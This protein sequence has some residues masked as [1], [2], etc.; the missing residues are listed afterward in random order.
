M[1]LVFY[2]EAASRLHARD[3]AALVYELMAPWQDQFVWSGALGYGH[4]RLWLG[5][6][7]ATLGRDARPTSISPSPAASTTTTA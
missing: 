5:V 6:A 1:T 4:V 3:A 2:T 7:A